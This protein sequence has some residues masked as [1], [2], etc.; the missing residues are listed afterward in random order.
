MYLFIQILHTQEFSAVAAD[1]LRIQRHESILSDSICLQTLRAAKNRTFPPFAG[2]E[3]IIL[4]IS[5]F[6]KI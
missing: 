5:V 3:K 4:P 6:S 2:L 1:L